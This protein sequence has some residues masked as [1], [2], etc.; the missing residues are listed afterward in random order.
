M[1]NPKINMELL[2]PKA[3]LFF[4]KDWEE[5]PAGYFRQGRNGHRG[6]GLIGCLNDRTV[7]PSVTLKP[8]QQL[9]SC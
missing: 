3:G 8:E 2:V 5:V 4:K 9:N 6:H 7:D 1:G